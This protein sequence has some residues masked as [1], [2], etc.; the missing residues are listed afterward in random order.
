MLDFYCDF[1][2]NEREGAKGRIDALHEG[3]VSPS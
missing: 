2:P 1:M 3:L